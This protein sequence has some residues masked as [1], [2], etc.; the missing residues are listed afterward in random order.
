MR[1]LT[2]V[3]LT[4][5]LAC[6][7]PPADAESLSAGPSD[8]SSGTTEAVAEPLA[9]D[10]SAL[11]AGA[12]GAQTA[13]TVEVPLRMLDGWLVVPVRTGDGRELRFGLSTGSDRTVLSE[14][15][16]ARIGDV[17]L[18]LG[19][20]AVPTE[21]H[22]TVPDSDLTGGETVLDGQVG[23]NVLSEYDVLIDVP[24]GRLVLKS[25][26]RD[27]SFDG[28]ALS[29]PVPLRILHG[30]VISLDVQ[31]NG[32]T[33]PASLVLGAATLIANRGVQSELSIGDEGT[34]TLG[35]GLADFDNVPV[36]VLDLD[37]FD[38]WSPT[39]AGFVLVG[40]P[41]LSECVASLSWL[42]RELRTCAR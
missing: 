35:L 30:V 41:F 37:V 9:S 22:A 5:L 24:G 12:R 33:Y 36:R 11:D 27:V 1:R 8:P 28:I 26:G 25:P 29:E 39:G 15:G 7:S 3:L 6:G 40:T 20:V 14:S 17:A 34:V 2:V 13:Q 32:T 38:R 31:L 19:G 16:E 18:D 21:P 4:A 23:S 10:S 42:H